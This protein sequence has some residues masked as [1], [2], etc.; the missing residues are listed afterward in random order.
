MAPASERMTLRTR[1]RVTGGC[2]VQPTAGIAW[3]P[4][5]S[6]FRSVRFVIIC[7]AP[8]M[9]F[10]PPYLPHPPPLPPSPPFRA[11]LPP[12]LLPLPPAFPPRS[13]LLSPP[14]PL[15]TRLP[16]TPDPPDSYNIPS[17]PKPRT[18]SPRRIAHPSPPFPHTPTPP[19]L[20]PPISSPASLP[21]PPPRAPTGPA[22]TATGSRLVPAAPHRRLDQQFYLTAPP[23]PLYPS[24][25]PGRRQ[26]AVAPPG[27]DQQPSLASAPPP[28]EFLLS[29]QA[30]AAR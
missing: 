7:S 30:A 14:P 22:S 16:S 23:R 11:S 25:A 8:L 13:S 26:P 1:T 5:N 15:F 9:T 4:S 6:C 12:R 19:V 28:H 24:T 10:I 27:L 2:R 18:L 20:L 3:G 29:L 17:L 21:P